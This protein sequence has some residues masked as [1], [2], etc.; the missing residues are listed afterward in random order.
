MMVSTDNNLFK[1]G[2]WLCIYPFPVTDS[3][4]WLSENNLFD[5]ADFIQD[6]THPLDY[7]YNAYWPRRPWEL[8]YWRGRTRLNTAFFAIKGL[9][10]Y[11][12]VDL[13][14]DFRNTV[15]G[16]LARG[17]AIRENYKSRTGEELGAKGFGS[18][19]S[20]TLAFIF[21]WDNNNLTWCFPRVGTYSH[22]RDLEP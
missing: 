18:S 4:N 20:F 17:S 14:D 21:D 7:A 16:W 8:L 6:T 9:K 2:D 19:A 3:P 10:D 12:A 13:A 15:L 1:G 22:S 5:K 11:G